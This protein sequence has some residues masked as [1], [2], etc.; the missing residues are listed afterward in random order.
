VQSPFLSLLFDYFGLTLACQYEINALKLNE[1]MR[2]LSIH[3]LILGTLLFGKSLMAQEYFELKRE[4]YPGFP[5]VSGV[6]MSL[7]EFL[8]N[9]PSYQRSLSKRGSELLIRGDSASEMIVVDPS[10]VWGYSQGGNVYLSFEDAFWRIINIGSLCHFTAV[11]VTSFQ[12]IDAFG[13][14]TMQYSKSMEHLFLDTDSG[15]I[16]ALEEKQL[17]PF[18]SKDPILLKK[19]ESKKRK[20]TVDLINALKAYNEIHTL[21][22]PINE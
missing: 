9:D 3:L 21:E 19:F 18:L 4:Y 20:K 16:Y 2:Q 17:K 8:E 5:F 1:L 14:P 11:I 6:Y 10:K 13:F 7:D 15:E 12:T 22:F